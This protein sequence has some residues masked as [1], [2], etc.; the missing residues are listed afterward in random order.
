MGIETAHTNI[1]K[2]EIFNENGKRLHA[3]MP[4]IFHPQKHFRW[5]FT[6]HLA[7]VKGKKEKLNLAHTLKAQGENRSTAL[8]FL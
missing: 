1:N 5:E 8:L 2:L 4:F 6:K 3:Q 7:K